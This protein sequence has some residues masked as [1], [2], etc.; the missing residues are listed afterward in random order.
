VA[1]WLLLFSI[2]TFLWTKEKAA[3]PGSKGTRLFSATVQSLRITLRE[4]RNYRQ[5]V[6]L[7]V[8]R[9]FYND[10]LLTIF[11]FGS[12][13]AAGTFGFTLS[14]IMIFG[15]VLNITAG[16]GA[17]ALGFLDDR[18]G[19]KRTIQLSNIAFIVAVIIAV[20][21]PGK[22]LFWCAGILIG[23]FS[24]PNQAASR[25][26][27]SRFVPA[28][29]ETE[30][31]GFYALS[32][33]ATAFAGPLILGLVT[34]LF[35]S[36]RVGVSVLIVLFLAGILLLARVDEAEGKKLSGRLDGI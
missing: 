1:A 5:I 6:R 19:G 9:I 27:M 20:M 8:A 10:A 23:L 7:L 16:A 15:I 22:T 30:F 29:K 18:I 17:F 36:Q 26:L 2:P 3:S 11:S 35:D 33:K 4:I 13:Y 34:Q 25:S 12:I 28:N 24:G 32:G 14:E 31:F 21:A